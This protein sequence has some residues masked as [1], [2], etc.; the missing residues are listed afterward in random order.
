VGPAAEFPER[1]A[2]GTYACWSTTVLSFR[3]APGT[4]LTASEVFGSANTAVGPA[5]VGEHGWA[6]IDLPTG[7]VTAL[8]TT[9]FNHATGEISST[10]FKLTGLPVVGFSAQTLD[11]GFINCGGA[12]CKGNYGGLF[13]LRARRNES[14]R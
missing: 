6:R 10:V 9:A 3:N 12:V 14:L 5:F 7:E 13:K 11:N 1:P 2:P 4:A 8:E